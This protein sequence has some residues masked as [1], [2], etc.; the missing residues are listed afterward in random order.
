MPTT[1]VVVEGMT[2]TRAVF[3]RLGGRDMVKQLGLVHKRVGERVIAAAGGVNTGVGSGTG[4]TIRPSA[5]TAGVYLRVGGSFRARF[6][7]WRQWGVT[8]QW[9]PPG[10]RPYLIGAALSVEEEILADYREGVASLA[11]P[12]RM[13]R[14]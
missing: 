6:G 3:N 1:R 8:Q 13:T 12:I 10:S 2:E 4:A 11:A 5:A 14:S 9:P 7:K